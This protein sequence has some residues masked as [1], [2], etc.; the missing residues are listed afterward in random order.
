MKKILVFVSCFP[1]FVSSAQ[2]GFYLQPQ[3]GIGSSNV[4]AHDNLELGRY[5]NEGRNS[6]SVYD[7]EL[8]IGYR[9][10]HLGISSGIFFLRSGFYEH[11]VSGYMFQTDT[12]TTQYYN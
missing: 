5:D 8:G 3:V 10:K 2:S 9:L 12:K 4:S 7:C 6:V 1:G 11:T